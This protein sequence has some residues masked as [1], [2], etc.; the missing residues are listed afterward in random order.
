MALATRSRVVEGATGLGA[1]GVG[2][3]DAGRLEVPDDA[4]G[5]HTPAIR[6]HR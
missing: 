4:V 5:E 6:G 3:V 2:G 1:A